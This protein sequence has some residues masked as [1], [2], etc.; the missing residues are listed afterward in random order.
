M[1]YHAELKRRNHVETG[2]FT[3]IQAAIDWAKSLGGPRTL[4]VKRRQDDG[5]YQIVREAKYGF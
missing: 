3:S 2:E 1:E 5:K 4:T